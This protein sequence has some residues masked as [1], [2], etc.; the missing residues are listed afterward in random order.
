MRQK[1]VFIL[2]FV[3]LGGIL[4]SV[5]VTGYYSYKMQATKTESVK[6]SE[7]G[8]LHTSASGSPISSV[9]EDEEEDETDKGFGLF[10]SQTWDFGC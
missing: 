8:R 9:A 6:V 10:S 3:F 2:G 4:G 5:C 7:D 1:I